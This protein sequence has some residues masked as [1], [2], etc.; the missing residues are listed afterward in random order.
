MKMLSKIAS[1]LQWNSDYKHTLVKVIRGLVNG[2][3]ME[4]I[5][6]DYQR[7]AK[8][9]DEIYMKGFYEAIVKLNESLPITG[10]EAIYLREIEQAM[11]P[12]LKTYKDELVGEILQDNYNMLKEH[13]LLGQYLQDFKSYFKG[14]MVAIHK[15]PES[16]IIIFECKQKPFSN[17]KQYHWEEPDLKKFYSNKQTSYVWDSFNNCLIHAL[18]PQHYPAVMALLKVENTQE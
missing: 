6:E 9:K 14:E 18:F 10:N 5:E 13:G 2:N 8:N 7:L 17:E 3:L 16:D 12:T 1:T 15:V 11:F 4:K